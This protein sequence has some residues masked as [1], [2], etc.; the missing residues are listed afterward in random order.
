MRHTVLSV[1]LPGSVKNGLSGPGGQVG[2]GLCL[3][4]HSGGGGVQMEGVGRE[5][6]QSVP[7]T[8]GGL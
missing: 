1:A 2:A 7:A 6:G 4:D 8:D 5:T 3:V